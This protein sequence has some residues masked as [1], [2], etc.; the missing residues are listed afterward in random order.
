ML[1]LLNKNTEF[2]KSDGK[3][4]LILFIL[5]SLIRFV[6][7]I[8][9]DTAAIS[10]DGQDWMYTAESIINEGRYGNEYTWR[11]PGYVMFL[12]AI[13]L[14]GK[15]ILAV[16]LLQVILGSL[17]CLI[18]YFIAKK[19]FSNPVGRISA[20][21]LCFYPYLIAY[22]GDVLCET[23]YTFL[24]SLSILFIITSAEKPTTK[25]L[26]L[27]GLVCGIT[28]L[29]KATILP[30]F[31]IACF[32]IWWRT[33]HIKNAF[34]LGIFTL[35][36]ISPWTLRNY[37]YM[38]KFIL[39]S[40]GY[41]T[42]WTS[43][44]DEAMILEK[45][46]EKDRPAPD[47]WNW[48]PDRF[49]KYLK[50]PRAEAEK[51]FKQEATE[52]IKNNPDKFMWLVKRRFI[53]FWRLYPMMAYKWQKIAAMFTSGLYIP[54]C[55]I[56]IILSIKNFRETS[57]LI[58]LFIIYTM[59]HLPFAVVLRYRVPID[60]Y[61]IIFASYTIHIIWLKLKYYTSSRV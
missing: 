11:P 7:V 13:F 8:N 42:L 53:H 10:P 1:N 16:R 37:L 50:L 25:N 15:S 29:T 23:F 56:G 46:G 17:T 30:F 52:W 18:I 22:T 43:N 6:Y 45:I 9:L 32:W 59:V 58:S 55:F 38:K 48:A 61:I 41:G 33:K 24:I 57:L 28:S 3:F 19:I 54:L 14:F 5:A 49:S 2:L 21:L 4:L 39:I 60:A 26:I 36:A 12:T 47:K 40:H 51:I 44:N 31:F 34:I 27:A 20:V 35:V